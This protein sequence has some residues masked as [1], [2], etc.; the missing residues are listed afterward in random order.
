MKSLKQK[1]EILKGLLTD[2]LGS[3]EIK[4]GISLCELQFE[5]EKFR[6]IEIYKEDYSEIG[7]SYISK[8]DKIDSLTVYTKED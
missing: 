6:E 8:N 4:I 2:E 5:L 1:F 3:N 7:W